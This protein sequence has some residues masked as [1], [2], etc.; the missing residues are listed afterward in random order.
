MIAPAP[1]CTQLNAK[2]ACLHIYA[3]N[4]TPWFAVPHLLAPRMRN[5]HRIRITRRGILPKKTVER[6]KR[7]RD[8][9]VRRLRRKGLTFYR[10]CSRQ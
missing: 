9:R 1:P 6:R 5:M 4:P 10:K 3:L 8:T 7:K 2:V